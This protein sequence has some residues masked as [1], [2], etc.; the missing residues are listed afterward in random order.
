MRRGGDAA[1]R[2]R[3]AT[4]L[5]TTASAAIATNPICLKFYL[6]NSTT[7]Q[8]L[9]DFNKI[10]ANFIIFLRLLE[11]IFQT[12]W[13]FFSTIFAGIPTADAP[14]G[15]SQITTALAPIKA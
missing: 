6:L 9:L 11:I 10:R 13:V 3:E 14:G 5:V 7:E 8:F 12:S 2:A 1:N 4:S 15:T